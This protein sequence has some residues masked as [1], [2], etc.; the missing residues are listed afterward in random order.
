MKVFIVAAV[1][2]LTRGTSQAGNRKLLSKARSALP[3]TKMGWPET[4][5]TCG[6][7]RGPEWVG[8]GWGVAVGRSGG[9]G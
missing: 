8:V 4:S 3:S 9:L 6:M 5:A 1:G 7:G 2:S